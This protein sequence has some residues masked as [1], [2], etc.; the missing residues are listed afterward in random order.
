MKFRT[1]YEPFERTDG[2]DFTGKKSRTKQ[3]FKQEC[4]INHIMKKYERQGILPQNIKQGMY[5][6]VSDVPTYQEACN[7]VIAAQEQFAALPSNVRERFAN[8]PAR[9]LEFVNDGSNAE[10]ME[11]LG[12]FSPEAVERVKTQKEAN[13]ARTSKKAKAKTETAAVGGGSAT[14]R[15]EGGSPTS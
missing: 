2:V 8:D 10:E 13:Q 12:L 14:E 3:S 6:D 5:A 4:D 7:L 1:A 15:S 9:F 11:K